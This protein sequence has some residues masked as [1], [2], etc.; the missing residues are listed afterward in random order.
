ME[1][2]YRLEAGTINL[3]GIL[4]LDASLDY[5][6]QSYAA[7]YAREMFLLRK[8]REGL[9]T[10]QGLRLYGADRLDHHLP[11]LACTVANRRSEDVGAILD[12]DFGIAVRAG[13]HCAPLVHQ[14]L[15]TLD[16]G[17]VRFSLGPFT[18]EAEIDAAIEA[19]KA[20]AG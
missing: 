3:F 5:V 18:T 15:G 12:G 16:N 11:V 10:L 8:L 14:D 6:E 19:M 9:A 13:L 1:Y 20:V 4:G 7:S 2:P 17:V